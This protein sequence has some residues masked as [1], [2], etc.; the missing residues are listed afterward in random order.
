VLEL[1]KLASVFEICSG[2][3]DAVLA[4]REQAAKDGTAGGTE[5]VSPPAGRTIFPAESGTDYPVRAP[6]LPRL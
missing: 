2:V 4:F 5:P 3:E 6:Q 1:T